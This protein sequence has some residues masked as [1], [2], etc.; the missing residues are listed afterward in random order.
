M[1]IT[2]RQLRRIIKE[3][4]AK[5]LAEDEFAGMRTD[6][7]RISSQALLDLYRKEQGLDQMSRGEAMT[8]LEKILDQIRETSNDDRSS[9]MAGRALDL[10]SL[11]D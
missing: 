2:K 9:Q 7:G 4:K 1:K 10:L 11:I 8:E 5:I 3:E 6:D